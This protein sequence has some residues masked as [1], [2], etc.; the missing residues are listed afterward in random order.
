[1]ADQKLTED[2]LRVLWFIRIRWGAIAV[3]SAILFF[4][5]AVAR[6]DIPIVTLV[7]IVTLSALYNSIYPFLVMKYKIFSESVL[8]TFFRVNVDLTVVTLLIHFTGGIESPFSLLY[9]VEF[10]TISLFGFIGLAFFVTVEWSAIF[11]FLCLLEAQHIIPHYR[12][13]HLPGNLYTDFNYVIS[14]GFG[15]F[16]CCALLI[17]AASFLSDKFKEKQHEIERLTKSREDFMNQMMH[18]AKSPLTS[19]MGYTDILVQG[20]FGELQKKQLDILEIVKRQS[21]RMLRLINDMLNIARLE[22]G[23]VTIKKESLPLHNLVENALDEMKPQIDEKNL[24]IVKEL[25]PNLTN[26]PMDETRITEVL[27]NLLSNAIKF[28]NPA[29][30]IFV[31]TQLLENKANVSVRDEGYGV[32]PG[33]LPNI[34][35]KFFRATRENPSLRG[36]GLGL[37]LSKTIVEAHGGKMWAVSDGR[38]QGTTIHFTLPL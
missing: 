9:L 8:F 25:D 24:L 11:M 37:S 10:L 4:L 26:V 17:Y 3:I 21:K 16:F 7:G 1:M 28:S 22:S 19:I 32:E 14:R 34:F 38:N 5:T 36:T 23:S 2:Q 20:G 30:K 33:D 18:E 35:K 15:L 13:S 29:G 6:F 31:S 12:L 27:I